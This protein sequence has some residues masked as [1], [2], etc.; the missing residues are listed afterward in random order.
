LTVACLGQAFCIDPV[1]RSRQP[2]SSKDYFTFMGQGE[3]SYPI[4][5]LH[6]TAPLGLSMVVVR[7]Q[8]KDAPGRA[9]QRRPLPL[10]ARCRPAPSD[11]RDPRCPAGSR[12]GRLIPV[13]CRGIGCPPSSAVIRV[14]GR[15]GRR[16]VFRPPK[17][18]FCSRFS[19][20]PFPYIPKGSTGS[21]MKTKTW[22]AR[23][24]PAMTAEG[25]FEGRRSVPGSN[26]RGAG[27]AR[28]RRQEECARIVVKPPERWP[29]PGTSGG[30]VSP[31]PAGA[32]GKTGIVPP[33]GGG[34]RSR[35]ETGTP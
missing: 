22:M 19:A 15:P 2:L 8:P 14:S 18:P 32:S 33:E 28:A 24:S 12:A 1:L 10:E 20:R 35:S 3:I 27:V 31:G 30:R 25:R 17:N 11:H 21:R 6:G 34:I 4:W 29:A 23:P 7:A 9:G 5:P 13:D 16:A 26:G